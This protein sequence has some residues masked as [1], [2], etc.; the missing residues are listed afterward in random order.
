MTVDARAAL[1]QRRENGGE[2]AKDDSMT[3]LIRKMEPQFQLAMPRGAEAQQ[4]VRDALTA[5]RTI[6]H[7][8]RCDPAS[9]LGSLMTCAQLGLRVGV[10]GQAWPIP[11]KK[12]DARDK[13]ERWNAQLIIGYQGY[14]ELAHRNPKVRSFIPRAV[15]ENDEFDVDYG[16][17]GTLIHKPAKGARG[18]VT[19]FHSI[20]KY[21]NGGYDFL[22]MSKEEMEEHRNR[23]AM[24]KKKLPDGTFEIFGVWKDHFVAMGQKTTQRLLAKHIPKSP[25][26]AVATFVDGGLR[27]DLNPRVPAEEVTRQIDEDDILQGEVIAPETG[28]DPNRPIEERQ[29]KAI[30][31]AATELNM[32]RPQR[33]SWLAELVKRPLES[34]NELTYS[35][36]EIAVAAMRRFKEQQGG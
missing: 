3:S 21:D 9:V 6:K 14:S 19:G 33:M 22:Y 23:F 36:A 5:L 32:D 30:M 4:L 11:F 8:D 10:L 28:A 17:A 16:V 1:D 29:R 27:I 24:T 26:L 18:E 12:W 25:D 35:E 13:V 15:H 7:L 31:A 20:A 34:S 2:V